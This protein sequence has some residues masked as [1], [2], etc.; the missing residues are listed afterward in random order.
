MNS[1]NWNYWKK[2]NIPANRAGS[3]NA[4]KNPVNAQGIIKKKYRWNDIDHGRCLKRARTRLKELHGLLRAP[5]FSKYSSE[6][7]ALCGAGKY[8]H[9]MALHIEIEQMEKNGCSRIESVRLC[10]GCNK[11]YLRRKKAIHEG[12]RKL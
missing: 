7:C 1:L 6:P 3:S 2:W 9:D 4:K 12:Y 5:E 8:R 10:K 11:K